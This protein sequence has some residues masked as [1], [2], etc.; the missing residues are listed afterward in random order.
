MRAHLLDIT[1]GQ[2]LILA[3]PALHNSH[4]QAEYLAIQ[5]PIELADDLQDADHGT[6]TEAVVHELSH[7][8]WTVSAEVV[9]T[10]LNSMPSFLLTAKHS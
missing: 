4:C 1:T 10:S 8:K 3:S 5:E 9:I 7:V 6:V 2:A